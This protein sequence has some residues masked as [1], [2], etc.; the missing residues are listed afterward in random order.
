MKIQTYKDLSK[1]HKI[2]LDM[3]TEDG[4]AII[5][6]EYA[7]GNAEHEISIDELRKLAAIGSFKWSGNGEE[8]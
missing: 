5:H 8:S 3:I 7:Q 4:N 2:Y 1:A 6:V